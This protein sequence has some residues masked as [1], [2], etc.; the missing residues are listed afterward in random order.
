MPDSSPRSLS[1][2]LLQ[3]LESGSPIQMDELIATWRD[4]AKSAW[5][6]TRI[7]ARG[8]GK[9][10]I[11]SGHAKP[12][13][14]EGCPGTRVMVRWPD[15]KRSWPCSKGLEAREDGYEIM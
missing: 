13:T 3:A 15:G 8:G 7:Y 11:A 6:G 14:L 12:C 1:Q 2:V 10:G 4:E 9:H 5:A